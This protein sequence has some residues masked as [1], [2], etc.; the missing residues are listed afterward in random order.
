ME[1]AIGMIDAIEIVIHL[2]AERAAR[3]GMRGIAEQLLGGA[4]AHLHDPAAGVRTI[5]SACAAND[6]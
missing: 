5:V 2:R 4:V 6:L 3:E 1:H